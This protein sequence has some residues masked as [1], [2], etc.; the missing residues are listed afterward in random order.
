M[1]LKE[2]RPLTFL[3]LK[4]RLAL[5]HYYCEH[6]VKVVKGLLTYFISDL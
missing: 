6:I 3:S 5:S 4:T 2:T 1:F